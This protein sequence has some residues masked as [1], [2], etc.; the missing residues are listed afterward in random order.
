MPK[1]VLDGD[2]MWGSTKLS[3]LP[4]TMVPEYSWFYP[5]ADANGSFEVT[6]LRVIWMKVSAIRPNLTL[7]YVQ[8]ILRTFGEHGLL[9]T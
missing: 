7:E 8:E 4:E 5:L 3:E 1:R 2:A 9:F 6:N